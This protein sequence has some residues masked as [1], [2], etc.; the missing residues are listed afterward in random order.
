MSVLITI[1]KV[2]VLAAVGYY[3]FK[4]VYALSTQPNLRHYLKHTLK[5]VKN[6]YYRYH[7]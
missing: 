4:A 6:M 3:L 7:V 5:D 2:A 1:L